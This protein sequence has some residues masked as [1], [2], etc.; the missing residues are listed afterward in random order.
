MR[1][2]NDNVPMVFVAPITTHYRESFEEFRVAVETF[3]KTVEGYICLD[4]VRSIDPTK[5]NFKE[6]DH[7]LIL[8][9]KAKCREILKAILNL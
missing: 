1:K 4:Q 5:R 9:C 2:F 6:S 8:G 7:K 3:S